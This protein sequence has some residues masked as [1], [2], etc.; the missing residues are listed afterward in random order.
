[1]LRIADISWSTKLFIVSSIYILGLLS[2]GV[3]GGYTI[4]GQNKA[5]EK[6]L[7]VS[8]SR[9]D[10]AGK[11][12][13][14]ILIMGRAQA[15]LLS[16]DGDQE[17]R[18]A[19][20]AA[21]GASSALDESIQRLQQALS[22][23]TKVAELSQLLRKIGPAKMEVIKAVRMKDD[24]QARTKVQSMQDDMARVESLSGDLVEEEENSLAAAVDDQKK[25][26]KSTV[27]VLG[28]LVGCG[29]VAGSLATW[30]VGRLMSRPLAALERSVRSLAT[31]DLTVVVPIFGKDE[32]G[33]TVSAMANMVH[34]LHSMVTNIHHDGESLT[35]HASGVEVA[36]DKL[37]HVSAKLH[38]TVGQIKND[39]AM[40]LSSTTTTLERLNQAASTAR[41]IA[42]SSQKQ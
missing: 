41:H 24:A 2:V 27:R 30:F 35:T 18:T 12:Q 23:S 16:A 11:A 7:K 39:A 40:V 28:T 31:G 22:G 42:S 17:R 13:V 3:L 1:V 25:Q 33:R 26:A 10:A 9:F 29:I 4:Y 15:Q 5:T 34:D 20:I 14:A 6:A 32:I 19:A 38:S 36:A 37:H 21:I 8:Q